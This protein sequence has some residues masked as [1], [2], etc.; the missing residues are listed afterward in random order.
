MYMY[1]HTKGR[2][3]EDCSSLHKC[4]VEQKPTITEDL[5]EIIDENEL[6]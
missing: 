5:E 3:E 1:R 6:I 2:E 4:P